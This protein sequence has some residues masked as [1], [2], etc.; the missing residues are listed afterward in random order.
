MHRQAAV[1]QLMRWL[2]PMTK[3][4]ASRVMRNSAPLQ[5]KHTSGHED[6]GQLAQRSTDRLHSLTVQPRRATAHKPSRMGIKIK[7]SW[8]QLC[9]RHAYLCYCCCAG[10]T[11][12]LVI[13]P[14][15]WWVIGATYRNEEAGCPPIWQWNCSSCSK[16]NKSLARDKTCRDY[17]QT[18]A[19]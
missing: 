13:L 10:V 9:V 12:A 17:L 1:A 15:F 3:P 4:A 7:G 18:R 5:H 14:I 16:D 11:Y 19:A 2:S 6:Q 8:L